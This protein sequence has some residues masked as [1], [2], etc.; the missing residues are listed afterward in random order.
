MAYLVTGVTGSGK[1]AL[2]RELA[3]RGHHAVS[4]D[5]DSQ[6]CTWIDRD[7]TRVP[8]PDA[9]DLA[10][11]RTHRW[12]WR[13][14][15]LDQLIAEAADDPLW[16]CGN[17]GNLTLLRDRFEIVYLLDIDLATM[18]HRIG[19]PN[20]GND[21]GRTGDTLTLLTETFHDIR[22]YLLRLRPVVVDASRPLAQVAEDVLAR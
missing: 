7:G 4:A 9:P 12:V 14:Y 20:R 21:F 18:L 19:N 17:A 16:L 10:W 11:L 3:R 15:R 8:R 13:P 5:G 6:L 2:A 1:S 22:A